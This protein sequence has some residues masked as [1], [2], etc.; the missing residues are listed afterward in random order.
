[1]RTGWNLYR[2]GIRPA[3]CPQGYRC[4][5]E[6]ERNRKLSI[7]SL[8]SFFL[9]NNIF[10]IFPS[11]LDGAVLDPRFLHVNF[12]QVRFGFTSTTLISNGHKHCRFWHKNRIFAASSV[13]SA[14]SSLLV[15]SERSRSRISATSFPATVASWTASIANSSWPLL[16]TSTCRASS[17][18]LRH[19][20]Y[21]TR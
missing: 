8:L 19:K 7:V 5:P 20:H 6:D 14:V 11:D 21:Y 12:R 15:S 10:S 13:P 3:R 2:T 9:I 17:S 1:M 4:P 18:Q 16:S